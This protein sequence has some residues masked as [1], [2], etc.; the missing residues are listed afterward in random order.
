M[1][2]LSPGQQREGHV[3][4]LRVDLLVNKED[5]VLVS[6]GKRPHL[7]TRYVRNGWIKDM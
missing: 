6:S 5:L 3:V 4:L 2:C 1:T 7:S